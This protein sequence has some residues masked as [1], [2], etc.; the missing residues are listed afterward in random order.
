MDMAEPGT[1]E[2]KPIFYDEKRRRWKRLRLILDI[3]AAVG[4][5]TF[6][7]FVL[8][9]LRMRPLPELL[10]EPAKHNYRA[11]NSQNILSDEKAKKVRSAHRETDRKVSDISFE[12]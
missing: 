10:L 6:I 7:V 3:S 1:R 2:Q 5:L 9:V 12:C 4:L 11:Q 8:G